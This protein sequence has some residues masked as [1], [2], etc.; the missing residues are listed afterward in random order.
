MKG[1]SDGG[2]KVSGLIAK[3]VRQSPLAETPVSGKGKAKD[4][5]KPYGIEI[6]YKGLYGNLNYRYKTE[7]ARDKA[8]ETLVDK[9]SRESKLHPD[10]TFYPISITKVNY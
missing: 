7:G 2:Y 5:G 1:R 9:D 10:R 6:A 3:D 4:K 8:Y